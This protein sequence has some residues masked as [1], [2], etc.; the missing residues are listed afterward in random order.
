MIIQQPIHYWRERE[1]RSGYHVVSIGNHAWCS[2]FSSFSVRDWHRTHLVTIIWW[3]STIC[4]HYFTATFIGYVF[5]YSAAVWFFYI[6]LYAYCC[7]RTLTGLGSSWTTRLRVFLQEEEE[8]FYQQIG[9]KFE[10]ETSEML[11][12][13]HGF[14]WCW[15]KLIINIYEDFI[16]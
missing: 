9:L 12:L 16:I 6:V 5:V 10:E 11:H 8:S 13:E 7:S 3:L 2:A 1:K 14:V 4:T 15:T